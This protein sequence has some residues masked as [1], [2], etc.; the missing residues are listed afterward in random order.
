MALIF[1]QK[2]NFTQFLYKNTTLHKNE[3]TFFVN[4]VQRSEKNH[5]FF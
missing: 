1:V 5:E 4:S 3:P 2:H